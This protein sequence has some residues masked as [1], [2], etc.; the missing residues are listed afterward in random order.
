P[1]LLFQG[2]FELRNPYI[3]YSVAPD[4]KHFAMLQVVQG[5]TT[6]PAL[7][8]VVVNWFARLQSLVAAGQK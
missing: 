3:P 4:G 2:G 8:T 6:A 1:E 5:K 7:P